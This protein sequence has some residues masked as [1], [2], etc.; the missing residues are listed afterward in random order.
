MVFSHIQEVKNMELLF[1]INRDFIPL[2]LNCT[3]SIAKNGGYGHY[4]ANIINSDIDSADEE[5]I[6]KEISP[7]FDCRFIK[8]DDSLFADFPETERYPKQIYYR[9]AAPMLLPESLERVLYLDV[10]L[11]VINSLKSLYES[12]FE[13]NYCIA[14]THT[15]KLLTQINRARLKM[16]ENAAYI[17]TGVMLMNLPLLREKLSLKDIRRYAEKNFRKLILPDQDIFSA[18]YG[19]RAK[20]ADTMVYNLSDRILNLYNANPENRSRDLEWVRKNSVI[21]HYFGKNKPWNRYYSGILDI[22]YREN[23]VREG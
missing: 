23:K 17:N 4:T 8:I 15:G 5:R 22:F 7:L 18:L 9:L 6:R 11:V 2:F 13:G 21:I 20:L 14:C 12:D 16:P 1:S 10:D 3:D 19:D